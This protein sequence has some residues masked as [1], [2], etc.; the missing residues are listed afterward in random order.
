MIVII[1][2]PSCAGKSSVILELV[3]RHN[4]RIVTG[5]T[6]RALRAGENNKI[7]VDVDEF[8]SLNE[9]G[10]IT[11]ANFHFGNWYGISAVEFFR[12]QSCILE[13]G[14]FDFGYDNLDQIPISAHSRIAKVVLLPESRETLVEYVKAS[15]RNERMPEILGEFDSTY[16]GLYDEANFAP[17]VIGIRNRSG[18]LELVADELACLVRG[19]MNSAD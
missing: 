3:V 8:R 2:G 5:Y 6:T 14:V 4:W 16:A 7:H 12:Y 15:G 9:A 1:S 19:R 11:L 18:R 10:E 17:E 13:V